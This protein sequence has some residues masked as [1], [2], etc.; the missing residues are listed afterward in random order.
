[1]N[2]INFEKQKPNENGYY[3]CKIWGF[4][5]NEYGN[6]SEYKVKYYRD[7]KFEE[8]PICEIYRNEIVEYHKVI[9]WAKLIEP[10]IDDSLYS[11]LE[12]HTKLLTEK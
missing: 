3:L 1:M 10:P 5:M 9:Y 2:W 11:I 4:S 12:E 6:R 8:Y 7:N